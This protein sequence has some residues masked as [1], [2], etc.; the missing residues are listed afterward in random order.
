VVADEAALATRILLGIPPPQPVDVASYFVSKNEANLAVGLVLEGRFKAEWRDRYREQLARNG[1][2]QFEVGIGSIGHGLRINAAVAASGDKP[3][4]M[5]GGTYAG[6][7]YPGDPQAANPALPAMTE[8]ATLSRVLV[9][10]EASAA[11]PGGWYVLRAY[12]L[13]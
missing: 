9:T 8:L 13:L 2:T 11:A 4:Y 3:S 6:P 5:P 1:G 12:P 10:I 7:M